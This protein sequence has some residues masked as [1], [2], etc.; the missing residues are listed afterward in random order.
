M[1]TCCWWSRRSVYW[2]TRHNETLPSKNSF[3]HFNKNNL[4][5]QKIYFI[6]HSCKQLLFTSVQ[7]LC[8]ETPLWSGW[9]SLWHFSKHR[10]KSQLFQWKISQHRF[11]FSKWVSWNCEWMLEFPSFHS[12]TYQPV[13][14]SYSCFSPKCYIWTFPILWLVHF[15]LGPDCS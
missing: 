14:N 15:V 8:W 4:K 7:S 9:I 11:T 13:Y 10:N 6:Q 3:R 12:L 2:V 5:S 1:E